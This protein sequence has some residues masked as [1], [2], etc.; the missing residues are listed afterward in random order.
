MTTV[1]DAAAWIHLIQLI[2][3]NSEA[4]AEFKRWAEELDS[5]E[6]AFVDAVDSDNTAYVDWKD[7]VEQ[8]LEALD[9]VGIRVEWPADRIHEAVPEALD[10]AARVF[11]EPWCM[12]DLGLDADGYTFVVCHADKVDALVEAA[13][14]VGFPAFPRPE[15]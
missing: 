1:Q 10:T 14:A 5:H 3:D 12:V 4:V 7:G 8:V 9:S 2:T 15:A 13:R 6:E 11:P